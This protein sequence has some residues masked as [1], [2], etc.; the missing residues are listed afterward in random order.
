MLAKLALRNLLRRKRRTTLTLLTMF[1]SFTLAAVSIGWSD[2]TYSYIIDSFTRSRYGHIQIHRRGYL[3]RPSLY[4]LLKGYRTLGRELGKVEGVEAWTPR[5]FASALL[6]KGPRTEA[7][8]LIGIDPERERM[9]TS[10]AREVVR[11]R[12]L[13][14]STAGEILLGEGLAELLGTGLG[15]SLVVVSQAADGSIANDVYQVVGIVKTGDPRED[16]SAA[17]LPLG[18]ADELLALGGRVHEVALVVGRISQVGKVVQRL[19]S[20]LEDTDLEVSPWQQFARSFYRAMKAD[21]QGMWISLVVIMIIMAVGVLN[22][23]LM[24]VLERTREYGLLKAL[25]TRGSQI[26]QLV[27]V[28][29]FFLALVGVVLGSGAA[30]AVNTVLSHRGI[31]LPEPFTYG[32]VEF[33]HL[34]TEVNLRSFL[35]PAATLV[36]C[37]LGVALAPALR[38]ARIEPAEALRRF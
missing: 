17:Y 19:Q 27:L 25:G 29:V 38:A 33:T 11:G 13:S 23:V 3:D 16:L 36:F 10:F 37:A 12:F 21:K 28:E 5:I 15:D 1:G 18:T 4:A 22:T 6:S 35:I 30:L 20:L 31:A 32:G 7:V 24:S 26:F 14:S 8:S 2:G 9:T 34:F